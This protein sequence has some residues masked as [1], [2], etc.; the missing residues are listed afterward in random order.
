[1]GFL[2]KLAGK[3]LKE[4]VIYLKIAIENIIDPSYYMFF[5]SRT[6]IISLKF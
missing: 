4:I 3:E 5:F 1:M 2:I 6:H